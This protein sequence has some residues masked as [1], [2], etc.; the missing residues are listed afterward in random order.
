M[1]HVTLFRKGLFGGLSLLTLGACSTQP[2]KAQMP[3]V[4]YI[5]PDQFR[6]CALS[7]WG[8]EGYADKVNFRPD[9]THTPVLNSFAKESAVLT[10]AVSNFPLSSPHR[11]ML[12]TGMYPDRSGVTL[13]C[14][15]D[16]PFSS[17]SKEAETIS[18]VFHKA[19]Y[20][21]GYIG[22]LHV[23]APTPNDPQNAGEYVEKRRPA[24]DAYTAPENRHNFNYW[25]SYGTYDVHKSPHYW[26]TEGNRH[27]INEWSPKH[28]ADKAIEYISNRGK[29]RD[30]NKPFFLVVSMNPPH[31]PYGSLDDCM[32]EDYN[33]YKDV[34]VDSLLVRPNADK[35][36]DKAGKNTAFYYA[37]ITGVDREFGR[38]LAALKEQG[39]DENTIVVF[40]SDHGETMCSQGTD[41]PKNSPYTEAL[42]IPFIVR[43]PQKISP[44]VDDLLLSSPD[45]MP[46]VLGLSGLGDMIPKAVEGKNYAGLLL[47]NGTEVSRPTSALYMQN[48]NGDK[49]EDGKLLDYFP[50]ARGIKTRDYTLSLHIDKKTKELTKTLFFDDKNDPYQLNNLDPAKHPE[51]LKK[52]CLDMAQL[53]KDTDDRW[54]KEKILADII[55]YQ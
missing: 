12:L 41:D 6:N 3:N 39:L 33:L 28:E 22:K 53:L 27:D 40:A 24:W 8:D 34:P 20:D 54:Y 36:M 55:P 42:N 50:A 48:V 2:E 51:I 4:I 18:D 23:D 49:G 26:D 15:S 35:T 19:G 32:E 16:R 31:G 47:D 7:F 45:I 43:Y 14:N 52:L 25:Y 17:L 5:F 10:S 21:C 30:G 29:V 1:K 44:K 37:S 11:G 38:I 9:P 13:N 46:T